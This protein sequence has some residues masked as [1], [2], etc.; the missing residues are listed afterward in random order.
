MYHEAQAMLTVL[1]FDLAPGSF[2]VGFRLRAWAAGLPLQLEKAVTQDG[3]LLRPRARL[4]DQ[5]V[6]VRREGSVFC[7]RERDYRAGLDRTW[8]D[9]VNTEQ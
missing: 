1:C 3:P 2:R 4:D 7:N 8:Q 6:M 9:G 5:R